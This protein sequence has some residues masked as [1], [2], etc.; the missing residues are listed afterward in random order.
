MSSVGPLIDTYQYTAPT[1]PL[2][3]WLRQ[4]P[5]L[6]LLG[7]P[8]IGNRIFASVLPKGCPLPAIAFHRMPGSS[9]DNTI[10]T[11]QYQF[12]CWA[13]NPG[14][15]SVLSSG[16]DFAEQMGARLATLLTSTPPRVRLGPTLVF[17]GPGQYVDSFFLPELK[18]GIPRQ[19][20]I[21]RLSFDSW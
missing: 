14:A 20:V 8:P 2:R 17:E 19:V 15:D 18:T 5:T 11:A 21:F 10:E 1:T 4:Q 6:A 16:P 9:I 13:P 7:D 12:D 3:D